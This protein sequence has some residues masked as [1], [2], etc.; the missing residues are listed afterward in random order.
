MDFKELFLIPEE[1]SD[2]TLPDPA[3]LDYWKARKNRI[4]YIDYEI[5]EDYSLIELSKTIINMNIEEMTTPKEELK[6]IY[7]F[8][9][10]YGGETDQANYFADLLISSRIPIITV[11]MGSAMSSGFL[12]FLAGHKRYAFKRCQMLVHSGSA[13]FSGTAEQIEEAQKNY[14]SRLDKMKTYIKE[15]TAI[16]EET[17]EKNRTKD[18]YLS[19]DD[20]IKYGIVDSFIGKIEDIF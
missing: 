11:G 6:P 3:E 13:G 1:I 17:F 19:D 8:I 5:D 15:R 16:D 2:L 14:K 20:L 18:W 10:S 7:I 9:H 4:F 12:I